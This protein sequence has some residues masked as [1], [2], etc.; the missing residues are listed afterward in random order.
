MCFRGGTG[1]G[2]Q[3]LVLP[4][5]TLYHRAKSPAPATLN[6][7]PLQKISRGEASVME[8]KVELWH[9][10]VTSFSPGF[11]D[12]TW[13]Q[14]T[15]N[16]LGLYDCFPKKHCKYDLIQRFPSFYCFHSWSCWKL[17]CCRQREAA[18]LLWSTQRVLSGPEGEK[19]L[20]Y[21][22]AGPPHLHCSAMS[23]HS[24]ALD[25]SPRRRLGWGFCINFLFRAGSQSLASS[26]VSLLVYML[27]LL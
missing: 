6:R 17:R 12:S 10:L 5:Q 4:R 23:L 25:C 8:A 24:S 14:E 13:G 16:D 3:G 20:H 1:D 7:I 2:T 19:L 27:K 26:L 22:R 9:C 18:S 21:S 15:V 11:A